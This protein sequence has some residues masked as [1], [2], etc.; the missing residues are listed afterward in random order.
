MNWIKSIYFYFRQI[1]CSLMFFIPI[2]VHA[3]SDTPFPRI[4]AGMHNA[5][6]EQIRLDEKQNRAISIGF[7]KTVRIW[8][9]PQLKLIRTIPLPSEAGHEGIPFGLAVSPD[10]KT[11]AVG[12]WTGWNW[13]KKASIY[14][15]NTDS[16]QMIKRLGDLPALVGTL[17]YSADGRYLAVGLH[18]GEG[19]RVYDTHTWQVRWQDAEYGERVTFVDVATDGRVATTSADGYVRLYQPDGHLYLRQEIGISKNLGGIRFSPDGRRIAFGIMDQPYAMVLAADGSRIIATHH[20]ESSEQKSLCCIAWSKNSQTLYLD[21]KYE[22]NGST[23]LYQYDQAGSAVSPQRFNVG[24]REFTN[25]LP[26]PNG[27]VLFATTAPS[28][29]IVNAKGQ[30]VKEKIAPLLRFDLLPQ[31]KI[32]ADGQKIGFYDQNKKTKIMNISKGQELD[33][34]GIND[35][36]W[37]QLSEP[38]KQAK[39]WYIDYKDAQHPLLNQKPLTL[40]KFE[41]IYNHTFAINQKTVYVGSGWAVRAFNKQNQQQWLYHTQ[42]PVAQLNA[43]TNGRWLVVALEDGTFRWL[44]AKTGTE[45]LGF[46]RHPEQQEW[47]IWRPDGL[48][49]S[50]LYGDQYIGWVINR[51]EDR[52]PRFVRAVQMERHLYQPQAIEG[53][54]NQTKALV[55]NSRDLLKQ[56]PP[57]VNI[58]QIH[59]LKDKILLDVELSADQRIDNLVTYINGI[60][61]TP[62]HHRKLKNSSTYVKT[63]VEIES[64]QK[65]LDIRL[66]TL[67]ENGIGLAEQFVFN[68]SPKPVAKG[69]LFIV[70][71]GIN[72]FVNIPAQ[73][74]NMIS[75][76]KYAVNDAQALSQE[77]AKKHSLFSKVIS[78]NIT[79]QAQIKPDKHNILSQLKILE[80]ATAQDTIIVYLASH[81]FNDQRG[82]YMF[83]TRDATFDDIK[84]VL[85]GEENKNS[86]LLSWQEILSP[87]WN[88]AGRRLLILDSC[89]A[90]QITQSADPFSILKRSAATNLAVLAAAK[91]DEY[92][93]EL[94]QFRHGLFT[95]GLL[96]GIQ[97][98]QSDKDKNNMIDLK[99]WFEWSNQIVKHYQD[100]RLGKQTPQL[101]AD[102][103][104]QSM[105]VTETAK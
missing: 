66:E 44:D 10:G 67:S 51:G 38:L 71:I 18:D 85:K 14:F 56:L 55:R 42:S 15:F 74:K 31:F 79:D 1:L 91:G 62:T 76:L 49:S 89:H 64:D 21:G 40:D 86:S 82:E 34:Q 60:P 22:G 87:L 72:E 93:Q 25:L 84:K 35:P 30:L 98:K 54:F 32:S 97:A 105:N 63:T 88:I 100:I 29:G 70:T 78:V 11:V 5:E 20:I 83:L 90:Q 68:R 104:M 4:D 27:D 81:G 73:Y 8:Q 12:G 17:S 26:L 45:M 47:V 80:Q 53:V 94:A 92:S 103:V 6:I 23:P 28:F 3:I 16:G 9:L 61:Y 46:Y 2:L 13:H 101:I 99:E 7:D 102:Q 41:K 58:Q 39:G 77:F 43:T 50:S 24:Q 69:R 37:S 59:Y 48:Y 52:T 96:Q 19:L 57:M 33:V 75:D 36:L 95:Y 65:E